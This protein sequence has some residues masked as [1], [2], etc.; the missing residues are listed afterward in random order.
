MRLSACSRT[1]T[2]PERICPRV[3]GVA[4]EAEGGCSSRG[5][6]A[7]VSHQRRGD[8]RAR[9]KAR[10]RRHHRQP[11]DSVGILEGGRRSGRLSPGVAARPRGDGRWPHRGR[12]AREGRRV[13]R[14]LQVTQEP[15]GHWA[16][17]MW[18]DGTPYWHG[19]QMDETALPILL[20]DLAARHGVLDAGGRD[21]SGRWCGEPPRFWCATGPSARRTA[22]RRSPGM[23]PSPSRPRS[24]RCWW[25][26]I[27][28]T[29]D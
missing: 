19:I 20:V 5:P 25:R 18:L 15:D 1:S 12:R 3:D 21:A 24:R 10:G 7:A 13:L 2:E 23:H 6:D 16:Q 29:Q 9:I 4:R 8:A 27:L 22:G 17:N 14:Y 26:R 11:V 28:P